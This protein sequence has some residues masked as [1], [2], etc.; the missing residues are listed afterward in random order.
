MEKMNK[1]ILARRSKQDNT[2]D[3][4]KFVFAIFVVGIHTGILGNGESF[5]SWFLIHWLFRI[6]VPFFFVTS[7][8][9]LGT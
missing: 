5:I 2:I 8:Y 6:A 7:G 4:L 9:Y 1:Y 3:F